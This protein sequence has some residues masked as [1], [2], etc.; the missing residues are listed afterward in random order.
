M[1]LS[2]FGPR[3][4][5]DFS[6]R[7]TRRE[8][9]GYYL[10]FIP[11]VV[12]PALAIGLFGDPAQ[13]APLSTVSWIAATV[14]GL[15]QLMLIGWLVAL[16]AV[17]FRRVHDIGHSAVNLLWGLLPFVGWIIMMVMIFTPGDEGENRF[18][19]DPRDPEG[20]SALEEIF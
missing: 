19:P 9:I 10:L 11:L 18:G 3:R 15:T 7:A 13:A 17:K 16:I 6:G 14:M 12:P 20:L 5:F 2:W 8:V 4:W 1:E